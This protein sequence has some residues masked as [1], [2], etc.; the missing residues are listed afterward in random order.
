[1][2]SQPRQEIQG[3]I[4]PQPDGRYYASYF[5]QVDNGPNTMTVKIP[6]PDYFSTIKDASNWL[7]AQALERTG[8]PRWDN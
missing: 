1:M 4:R 8:S 5:V 6:A 7:A 3:S 2:V